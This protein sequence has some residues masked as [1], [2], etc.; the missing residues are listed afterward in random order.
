MWKTDYKPIKT[1]QMTPR[2]KQIF[3]LI[4]SYEKKHGYVPNNI[5]IAKK[6]GVSNQSIQQII[7]QLIKKGHLK[8]QKAIY[9]GSYAIPTSPTQKA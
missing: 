1:K 4:L 6:L 2:Q 3:T 7:A 9:T 8:P 5:E